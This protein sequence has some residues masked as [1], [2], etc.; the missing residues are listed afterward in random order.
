V[1]EISS[2]WGNQLSRCLR[3]LTWGRKQIQFPKRC[4]FYFLEYRTMDEV[5]KP[6]NSEVQTC[7]EGIE[8]VWPSSRNGLGATLLPVL[9][10]QNL[11]TLLTHLV[12]SLNAYAAVCVLCLAL[13]IRFR[14][15]EQ[16][17]FCYVKW[18]FTYFCQSFRTFRYYLDR[19][20]AWKDSC[21]CGNHKSETNFLSKWN[22]LL[23]W[24]Q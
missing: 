20:Q 16:D 18:S 7:I 5:Q 14:S 13:Q 15:K 4:V 10:L 23:I 2:F 17:R 11:I 3:P 1:I 21:I 6:S 22:C 9:A 8:E 19:P 24:H 12:W